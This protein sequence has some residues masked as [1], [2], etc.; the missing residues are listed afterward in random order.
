MQ[1]KRITG[2]EF[3]KEIKP[4]VKAEKISKK[5]EEKKPAEAQEASSTRPMDKTAIPP[6]VFSGAKFGEFAA[7]A[8]QRLGGLDRSSPDFRK[9]TMETTVGAALEIGFG[10]KITSDPGYPQM[11]DKIT[12]SILSNEESAAKLDKFINM[13]LA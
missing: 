7:K 2:S 3:N 11:A 1:E 6:E 12:R 4:A 9:K 13:L 10:E 8:Q 5:T